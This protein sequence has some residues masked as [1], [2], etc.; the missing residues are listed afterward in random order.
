MS[1]ETIA[2]LVFASISWYVIAPAAAAQLSL[3][4]T[5]ERITDPLRGYI[6]SRW[7][8]SFLDYL[9]HC[10]V[11]TSYWT[12]AFVCILAFPLWIKI[13]QYIPVIGGCYTLEC[14]VW[15]TTVYYTAQKVK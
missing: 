6:E 11:C 4:I 15:L 1:S 8:G 7:P 12:S 5:Q 13:A 2:F 10:P 3:T 9:I 14:L